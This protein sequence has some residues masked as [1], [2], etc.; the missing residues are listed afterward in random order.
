ML[1]S[2]GTSSGLDYSKNKNIYE[3]ASILLIINR[4]VS[5][6]KTSLQNCSIAEYENFFVK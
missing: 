2:N 3:F 5:F 1:R 4:I 6:S